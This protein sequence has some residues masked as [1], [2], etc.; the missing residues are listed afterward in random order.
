MPA[1]V[2]YSPGM[3][4]QVSNPP[5]PWAS[6]QIAWLEEPPAATLAVFEEQ[7]RS[8]LSENDSPD[9]AFRFSLNPYRGCLHACAY[10]YARPSHQYLGWGAGTDFD[11][12]IVVKTN[13]AEILRK[14]LM[15]P[16]WQGELIVF[17]GNTDCYQPLEASYALTRRCL[18]VC[19]EFKNPVRIITKGALI[20]RD[21]DIL[22]QLVQSAGAAVHIS[23]AF[24]RDDIARKMEPYASRPSIRFETL[25]ALSD[26][27]IPT[28][29]ALAPVIP[30]LNDSDIAELLERAKQAGAD[31]AF[32]TLL[33]LPREV[34]PVFQERLHEAFP[35]RA[36]KVESQL[37]E[38]RGGKVQQ[39]AF[40]LRFAGKGPRWQVIEQLFETHCRRLG[41]N[42][43]P[44]A[45]EVPS[46]F[47]RPL[48]QQKL[49]EG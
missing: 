35:E 8:V 40:G 30:G 31:R 20:R 28:G 22:R 21:I 48:M 44:L 1:P 27:G 3:P 10:C 7:A 5:N 23:I 37:M 16:S 39:S 26:A 4:R 36:R 42:Q 17:S 15:R 9:L 13:A 24:A 38:A 33:R 19:L 32:M 34:L 47:R 18:E 45:S 49:F 2:G 12:K 29:I 6:T 25:R 43:T 14:E 46:P 41:L 11:R